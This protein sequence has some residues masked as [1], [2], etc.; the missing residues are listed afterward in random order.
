MKSMPCSAEIRAFLA[1]KL[2]PEE[3][4]QVFRAVESSWR[5]LYPPTPT[6]EHP[7][8]VSATAEDLSWLVAGA[9]QARY[10]QKTEI[11]RG[12]ILQVIEGGR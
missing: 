9:L 5:I 6:E 8:T 12:V 11:Q 2:R 10:P 3:A 1:Q 4:S 7:Y